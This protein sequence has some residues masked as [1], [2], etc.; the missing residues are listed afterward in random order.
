MLKAIV[1]VVVKVIVTAKTKLGKTLFHYG[2]KGS[3]L[4]PLLGQGRHRT[5]SERLLVGQKSRNN[6][7]S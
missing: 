7:R 3:L 6:T 1:M 4:P 5:Y 2:I